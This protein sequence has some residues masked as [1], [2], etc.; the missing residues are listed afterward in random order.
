[1]DRQ[2]AMDDLAKKH[3][4]EVCFDLYYLILCSWWIPLSDSWSN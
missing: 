4:L 1:L 2:R 3:Q